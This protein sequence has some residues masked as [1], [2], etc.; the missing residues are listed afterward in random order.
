MEGVYDMLHMQ[1][2]WEKQETL[3]EFLVEKL[4]RKRPFRTWTPKWKSNTVLKS[5]VG[6]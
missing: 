5:F 1:L 4:R 3:S 2:G 6:K